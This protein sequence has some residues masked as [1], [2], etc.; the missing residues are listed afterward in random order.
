VILLDVGVWLAAV[1]GR[2]VHNRVAAQWFDQQ[3]DD[4]IFC[5]ITRMSLLRLLSNPAVMGDDVLTRSAAWRTIDQLW[6]DDRVLWA[7]E[8]TELEAVL[9]AFSA[10]DDHSHKLWT[11]DYLAAFAQT[12]DASLATLDTK[13][14]ERYPSVRIEPLI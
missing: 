12:S 10:R 7:D 2:H 3:T 14:R 1:W 5:R 4:L 9:R 8:P 13:L 6:A 11:D